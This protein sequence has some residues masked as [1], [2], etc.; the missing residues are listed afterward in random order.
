MQTDQPHVWELIELLGLKIPPNHIE[1][2]PSVH[3]Q[4]GHCQTSLTSGVM[5]CRF[6]YDKLHTIQWEQPNKADVDQMDLWSPV[7][8]PKVLNAP[9][10]LK[11]LWRI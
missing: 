5:P 3:K 10:A 4:Y 6:Q 1:Y 11:T 9:I 2:D 8:M 7:I